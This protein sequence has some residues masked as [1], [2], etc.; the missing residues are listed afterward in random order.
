VRPSP[1]RGAEFDLLGCLEDEMTEPL[2][3]EG[4]L[5]AFDVCLL[6]ALEPMACGL[7][8]LRLAW[9]DADEAD[10]ALGLVLC[11]IA[12]DRARAFFNGPDCP[13]APYDGGIEIILKNVQARLAF[14]DR[15]NGW[16]SARSD[17]H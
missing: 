1:S 5:V 7:A 12:E 10:A 4:S 17:G 3:P 13:V 2:L 11:D 6:D 8:M 16:L 15:F 14:K 9:L